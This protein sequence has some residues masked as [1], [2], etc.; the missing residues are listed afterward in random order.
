MKLLTN[1]IT[2]I[3]L[4]AILLTP[5]TAKAS[6]T[7]MDYVDDGIY[8][9]TTIEEVVNYDQSSNKK[10]AH[11]VEINKKKSVK[12]AKKT[13]QYYDANDNLLWYVRV[14]GTFTYDGNT[15]TCTSSSVDAASNNADWVVS[16]KQSSKSNNIATA[17]AT[18]TR[19]HNNKKCE[20]IT[21]SVTVTCS[22]NGTIS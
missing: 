14:T 9:I 13:N 16:N 10:R 19:Y 2:Y 17:K 8:C 11:H 4:L 22:K 7:N 15:C 21:K 18:G 6:T 12:T 5:T 1:I 20:T 3:A